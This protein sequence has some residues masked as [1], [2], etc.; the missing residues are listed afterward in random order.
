MGTVSKHP[1]KSCFHIKKMTPY[2]KTGYFWIKPDCVSSP[3]R[4]FCDFDNF[5]FGKDI[6]YYGRTATST[7]FVNVKNRNDA[8]N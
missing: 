1:A 4:V 5:K 6:A 8:V 7:S 3:L 2:K